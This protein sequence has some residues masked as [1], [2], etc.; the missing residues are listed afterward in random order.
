MSKLDRQLDEVY[1]EERVVIRWPANAEVDLNEIRD[2]LIRQIDDHVQRVPLDLRRVDGVPQPLI[3]LLIECQAY[4]RSSG[5][6]LSI[7]S[8]RPEMH[9]ALN[10]RPRRK[11]ARTKNT[12]TAGDLAKSVLDQQLLQDEPPKYDVSKAEKIKRPKKKGR[13]QKEST[14]KRYAM[15]AAVAILV[16][17]VIGAV[18][19]YVIFNRDPDNMIVP[20]KSFESSRTLASPDSARVAGQ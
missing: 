11:S 2:H 8:A 15:L 1:G 14:W 20:T 4:A 7:S 13:H 16:T 17:G 6:V 3:D 12:V 10:G 5:K 18:E 9:D 19:W